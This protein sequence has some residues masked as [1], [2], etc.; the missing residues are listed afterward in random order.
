MFY[1]FEGFTEEAEAV[2][3]VYIVLSEVGDILGYRLDAIEALECDDDRII[4]SDIFYQTRDSSITGDVF[5]TDES[6]QIFID[7][8]ELLGILRF[9]GEIRVKGDDCFV[10]VLI[11]AREQF[12][13][14]V[15]VDEEL[16]VGI[17]CCEVIELLEFC[18]GAVE[19]IVHCD[20]DD[21]IDLCLHSGRLL[22]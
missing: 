19:V 20:A 13:F 17:S 22:M 6:D 5:D 2:M 10:G 1:S 3:C 16:R 9:D 7:L 18:I 11:D 15:G 12:G 4:F 14:D 21:F 8:F